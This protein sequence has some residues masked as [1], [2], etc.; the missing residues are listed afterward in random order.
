[1]SSVLLCFASG[2]VR[3]RVVS[4]SISGGIDHVY[5][6]YT[7]RN[8]DC[9]GVWVWVVGEE[10]RE[11]EKVRLCVHV[12]DHLC[13]TAVVLDSAASLSFSFTTPFLFDL[14]PIPCSQ[15]HSK[16]AYQDQGKKDIVVGIRLDRILWRTGSWPE[17]HPWQDP[18]LPPPPLRQSL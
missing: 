18:C 12:T 15:Q 16:E 14:D 17:Q 1:M 4:E 13:F 2:A 9:R 11:T 6:I 10:R 5:T 8:R 7:Y 3:S